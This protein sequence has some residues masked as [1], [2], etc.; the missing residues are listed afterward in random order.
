M[1]IN[2]DVNKFVN[3]KNLFLNGPDMWLMDR[4]YVF[5]IQFGKDVCRNISKKG[6]VGNHNIHVLLWAPQ[7]WFGSK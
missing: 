4:I 1:I 2:Y 3:I 6:R 7:F 5:K